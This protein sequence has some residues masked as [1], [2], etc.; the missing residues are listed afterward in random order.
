MTLRKI[1]DWSIAEADGN[2]FGT[3][4][5]PFYEYYDADGNFT[6]A[7][8][9]DIGQ[10][11][12]LRNVPISNSNQ[13][14]LYAQEGA[15]VALSK[16]GPNKYAVVGLSKKIMGNTHIIYVGF[17]DNGSVPPSDISDTPSTVI[18]STEIVG[19]RYRILTYGEIGSI[20]GGYG[21]IPYGTRGKFNYN[22][23]LIELTRSF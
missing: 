4:A 20:Y 2:C 12:V 16:M 9:V 5:S 11:E 21:T 1:I 8:D 23:T 22:G 6:Y 7:C 17:A 14:L 18:I 10:E 15:P 13:E 19:Y 3:I